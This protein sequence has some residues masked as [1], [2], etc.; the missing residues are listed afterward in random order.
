MLIFQAGWMVCR[1]D[2]EGPVITALTPTQ[3]FNSGKVL[4]SIEGRYFTEPVTLK[5]VRNN[6]EIPGLYPKVE[7]GSR[8]QCFFDLD[9]MPFGDYD[10]VITTGEGQSNIFKNSFRIRVFIL[11]YHINR[12]IKPISFDYDSY[13]IPEDQADTLQKDIEYLTANP[14]NYILLDG[15]SDPRGT[16]EYNLELSLKRV[17]SVKQAIIKAGIPEKRVFGCYY[18]KQYPYYISIKKGESNRRV[19]IILSETSPFK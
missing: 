5:L 8:I 6:A 12:L 16:N 13:D 18:G 10:L 2:S 15:C 4:L 19:Y 14:D 1:G 17:E 3:G 7:A 11:A 9:H